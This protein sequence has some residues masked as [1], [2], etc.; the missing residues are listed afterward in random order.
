MNILKI[1]DLVYRV[2]EEEPIARDHDNILV[3]MVWHYQLNNIGYR[4]DRDFMTILGIDE[5]S[6]YESISRCA[7]KI[8]ED[9]ISLRGSNYISRQQ[10][11]TSVVRQIRE[12]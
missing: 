4:G 5:L 3:G 2:L 7:R 11:Q 9:N 10:E 12:F 1:K 8:K 6:K